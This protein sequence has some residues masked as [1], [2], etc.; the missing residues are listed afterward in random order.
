MAQPVLAKGHVV[1][2]F[3]ISPSTVG[4][5]LGCLSGKLPICGYWP[6]PELGGEG[7][8]YAAFSNE[9]YDA[10][11]ANKPSRLVI[12]SPLTPQAMLGHCQTDYIYK[13]FGM[14]SVVYEAGYRFSIPVS[15]F[16]AD[17]VRYELLGRHRWPG[18]SEEAKKVVLAH[19]RKLGVPTTSYDA[20]DAVMVWLYVQKQ[21][22]GGISHDPL[23]R[24]AAD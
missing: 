22:S 8:T 1:L 4:Y 18:G 21:M 14:R 16:S 17:K 7:A 12:E 13:I 3:D 11:E 6:M 20:A 10:I 24:D 2:A 19:V 5:A 23:F 15:G 9:V